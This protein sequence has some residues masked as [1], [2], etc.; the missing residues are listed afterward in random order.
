MLIILKRFRKRN[1]VEINA[2]VFGASQ[3]FV[4]IITSLNSTFDILFVSVLP[5]FLNQAE[6]GSTNENSATQDGTVFYLALKTKKF[7]K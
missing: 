6:Q 3:T 5:L 4:I 1:R 7:F 2:N